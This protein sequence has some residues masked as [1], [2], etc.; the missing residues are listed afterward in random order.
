MSRKVSQVSPQTV[1][2]Q[3]QSGKIDSIWAAGFKI[4][5]WAGSEMQHITEQ[6]FPPQEVKIK[7]SEKSR[8]GTDNSADRIVMVDKDGNEIV[9][10]TAIEMGIKFFKTQELAEQY[11]L[12][13]T[14]NF[15]KSTEKVMKLHAEY[16]DK[17]SHDNP[18]FVNEL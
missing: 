4:D 17:L 9:R 3:I 11:F 12:Y 2:R 16:L 14:H 18:H 15:Y 8:W 1:I 10:W 13:V 7:L 6:H 5:K